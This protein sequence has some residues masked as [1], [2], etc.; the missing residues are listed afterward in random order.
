LR[1]KNNREKKLKTSY[2]REKPKNILV[3]AAFVAEMPFSSSSFAACEKIKEI[4]G[5][6][7]KE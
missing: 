7:K 6:E 5:K 1:E 4:R 3:S 2:K